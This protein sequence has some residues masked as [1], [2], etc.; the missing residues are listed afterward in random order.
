MRRNLVVMIA[1]PLT[2]TG[3]ALAVLNGCSS[4]EATGQASRVLPGQAKTGSVLRYHNSASRDGV[5][6]DPTLTRASASRL[7]PVPGFTATVS[8]PVYAQPLYMAKA[9][10]G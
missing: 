3:T 9:V 10:S 1:L 6:V 2:V 8:G 7:A 4:S 5:Y